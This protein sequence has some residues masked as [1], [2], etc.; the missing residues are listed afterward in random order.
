MKCQK[1]NKK[2]TIFLKTFQSCNSCFIKIIEQRI[3]KEIRET[4]IFNEFL[5]NN[6]YKKAQKQ[7]ILINDKSIKSLFN[8]YFF[9]KFFFQDFNKKIELKEIK[10]NPFKKNEKM[11]FINYLLKNTFKKLKNKKAEKIFILPWLLDDESSL[12]MESVF[13]NKKTDYL[14]HFYYNKNFYFKPL[15]HLSFEELIIYVKIKKI[16]IKNNENKKKLIEET[17]LSNLVK[18]YPEINFAILKSENELKK[19]LL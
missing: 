12:F 11:G 8:K 18:E 6:N 7:L 4:K 2:A 14:N 19:S 15:I 9:S 16:I 3:R 10:I 1:C 13:N 17:I 5:K